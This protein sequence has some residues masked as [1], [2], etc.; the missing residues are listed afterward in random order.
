MVVIQTA[1]RNT[2]D[3]YGH[4]TVDLSS[5]GSGIYACGGK[6]TAITW[7]KS[8]PDGQLH[9]FDAAGKPLVFGQGRTYVNIV[10]L[11]AAITCE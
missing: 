7:R 9:Y 2:G 6:M 10:P 1:C 5:G 3:S 4:I 8:A 11:E